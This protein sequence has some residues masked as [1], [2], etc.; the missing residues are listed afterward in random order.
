MTWRIAVSSR[1]V[2]CARAVDPVAGMA[3]DAATSSGA[4]RGYITSAIQPRELHAAVLRA[5]F[6]CAVVGNRLRLPVALCRET[7]TSDALLD[8]VPPDRFGPPAREIE[9][10]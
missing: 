3:S 1:R 9:V 2:P 6:R 8:Q 10:V 4:S 7:R 5:A